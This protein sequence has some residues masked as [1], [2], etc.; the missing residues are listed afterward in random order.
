MELIS[1]PEDVRIDLRKRFLDDF[2]FWAKHCCKI[3]TKAGKIVPLILNRVQQRFLKCIL[4]QWTQ[5]GRVRFVVLK[6]RQQG[7]STVIMAFQYWWLSQ[8]TAQKGLVMAHEADGTA[9]LFDMYKRTHDNCPELLRP[10]TKYSS[11]TELTFSMLDT[12][13]RVATAGGRGIARGETLQTVHLSEVAFWPVA[14][15]ESN[16][17]GLIQA[18]PN[19]DNTF[20]FVES[21]AN[22]M[23]GKFYDLAQRAIRGENEFELFFSGWN[24]SDEYRETAPEG[25]KRT[26]E[27]Q[28]LAEQFDLDDDQLYWRRRK[29]GNTGLAL[30]QQEYPLTPDEA[31]ISTGRPVFNTEWVHERL[32][33]KNL[34]QPKRRCVVTEG[35]LSDDIRGELLIYRDVDASER[36]VIGA[37]VGMGIR[38]SRAGSKDSDPSVAH[39]LDSQLR[40]AAVWSGV[41]HPDAFARVLTTLGYYYN[42]A[43]IAPERNNHG[44]LTCVKLRD[45]GYPYI[46]TDVTEGALD[47]RDSINIGYYVTER[48]KPLIIDKLRAVLRDR[49]MEVY[50]ETTLREMLSYVV[51]DNGKMGA[52]PGCHDDHIMALAVAN[53][54]HEGKWAPITVTEDHY[55]SAI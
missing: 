18:V 16:F 42:S 12:G 14:F 22:G 46:Y 30:F 24:E 48:T 9:T 11:K 23:S 27:E 20:A 50:D 44:L 55:V 8:R 25:F 32:L 40:Q 36:Y 28:K 17:N 54:I 19:E 49:E 1:L 13:I 52:E 5:T 47:D 53:Q 26:P 3:R 51:N 33:P 2:E 6:A 10:S 39:V 38:A 37:D 31:F 45:L 43:M 15:A 34:V 21:T 29:V 7:L 41:I 4:R 35:L